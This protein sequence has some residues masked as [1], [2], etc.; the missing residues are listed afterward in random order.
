MGGMI[1]SLLQ[2]GY[3]AAVNR[4]NLPLPPPPVPSVPP[5]PDDWDEDD[6]PRLPE[7][8]PVAP[9]RPATPPAWSVPWA[10]Q[11][12]SE[13][14]VWPQSGLSPSRIDVADLGALRPVDD[15][16][17]SSPDVLEDGL[18]ASSYAETIDTAV[19]CLPCFRRHASTAATS[20]EF[21]ESAMARG[22]VQTAKEESVRAAGEVLLFHLY[23]L[24][25]EKVA[26]TPP[27]TMAVIESARPDLLEAAE[28]APTPPM[29]ALA[30]WSSANEAVRFARSEEPAESDAQEIALRLRPALRWLDETESII[31]SPERTAMLPPAQRTQVRA[32]AE[33]LRQARHYLVPEFGVPTVDRMEQATAHLFRAAV[34]LTPDPTADQVAHV[35]ALTAQA[36]DRLDDHLLEAM[37]MGAL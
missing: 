8:P 7:P 35:R 17:R 6:L 15:P 37:Q 26:A 14:G 33:Q 31:L 34:E 16:K 36:M 3:Q 4:P 30:A 1:G 28:V 11:R 23:D 27:E 19:A 24:T 5:G 10:P 32:A 13:A 18:D 2:W 12:V 25:E 20:A 21:A 22:D 9:V 29:P